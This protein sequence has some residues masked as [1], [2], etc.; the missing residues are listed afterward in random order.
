MDPIPQ[1]ISRAWQEKR[2]RAEHWAPRPG[3]VWRSQQG[4]AEGASE[5]GEEP[6]ARN[7]WKPGEE[8]VT[9]EQRAA[10]R[11]REQE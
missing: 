8:N 2:H 7:S 3:E 10:E 1:G 5:A 9:S 4:D 11:P 6:R